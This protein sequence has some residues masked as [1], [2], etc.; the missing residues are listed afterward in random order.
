[1]TF[2]PFDRD[3]DLALSNRDRWNYW[4]VTDEPKV[5]KSNRRTVMR[6]LTHI[7][8]KLRRLQEQLQGV[9]D[10]SAPARLLRIPDYLPREE[11]QLPGHRPT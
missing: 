4:R 11:T 5:T 1:M 9:L 10:I 6:E 2:G 3:L 8:D 7:A